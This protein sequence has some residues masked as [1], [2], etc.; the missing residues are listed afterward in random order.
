M[1]AKLLPSNINIHD[2][3]NESERHVIEL[4]ARR[5]GSDWIISPNFRFND[6]RRDRETDVIIL[7]QHLGMM[8]LEIKG[9]QIAIREG[10]WVHNGDREEPETQARENS[11][12]LRELLQNA[13]PEKSFKIGWGVCLPKSSSYT[14]DLPGEIKRN[15]LILSPDLEDIE[16]NLERA[17]DA[18]NSR[19]SFSEQQINLILGALYPEIEFTYDPDAELLRNRERLN[20]ICEAQVQAVMSLEVHHRVMVVGA[21]GTGKTYL[22]TRWALSGL[23]SDDERPRNILL[24]CYNDPLGMQFQRI[25]P[26]NEISDEI[27]SQIYTGPLMKTLMKLPGMPNPDFSNTNNNDYWEEALPAFIKKNLS[28]VTLR[29]DRIIVDEAQDFSPAWIELLESLLNPDCDN[30]LFLL[31]D[32][33]Q[34]LSNRGFEEPLINDGWVRCELRTNVRNSFEIAKLA[35]MFLDGAAAPK[36]LPS[37]SVVKF[38]GINSDFEIAENVKKSIGEALSNGLKPE[39]I[40]VVASSSVLRDE[41]RSELQLGLADDRYNGMIPCETA[42]RSKGLEADFVVVASAMKCI[43]EAELYVGI[44]RAIS[45]LTI[46]GPSELGNR[47]GMTSK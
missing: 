37:S 25:F 35:R 28:K 26:A 46:I 29:F 31:F 3:E 40:L 27:E 15:Q 36:S 14:G 24:T 32:E 4:L 6:G 18:S 39:Q 38:T 19:Y 44:T 41:L 8:I 12:A 5:L 47:L 16:W 20:D 1:T 7:N 43:G 9:G 17:I 22:A 34:R 21:A 45:Q 2:I 42:H 33:K 10:E 30:Q 23:M 11:Y 13:M